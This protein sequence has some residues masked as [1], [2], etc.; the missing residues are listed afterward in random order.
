MIAEIIVKLKIDLLGNKLW[1]L[2]INVLKVHQTSG[3]ALVYTHS[4]QVWL[5]ILF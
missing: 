5:P 4:D 3:K 2:K 1:S